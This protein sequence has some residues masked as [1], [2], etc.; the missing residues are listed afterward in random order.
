MTEKGE[1]ANRIICGKAKATKREIA[2]SE[3]RKE[4][5]MGHWKRANDLERHWR[6]ERVI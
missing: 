4:R 1:L 3:I 2:L 6:K 5:A